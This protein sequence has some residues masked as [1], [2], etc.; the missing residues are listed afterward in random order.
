V[1][2]ERAKGLADV[3]GRQRE[4]SREIEAMHRHKEAQEGRVELNIGGYRFETSVQA[5]RRVPHTFFDAYFSG[6]YAQDVCADGSIFVDRDGKHFGHVLE[7]MR[8]GHVSVA[9]AGAC[10]S[11][12]LLRALKREFGFYCIELVVEQPA[13]PEQLETAYVMGGYEG[14]EFGN[15]ALSGMERFDASSGQWSAAASMSTPRRAFGACALGG[16]LYVLGGRDNDNRWLSS[17]EKYSPVSGT[18]S[19]VTPMPQARSAHVAVTVGSAIY[20]LGGFVVRG[21]TVASVLKFDSM[22]GTWS[23]VAPM[24]QA[25]CAVAACA[26]GS[27]IFV[28]GGFSTA[29]GGEVHASVY[30]LDTVA[31]EWSTLAPIPLGCAFHSASI[32]DGMIYIVGAG[33]TQKAVLR[34]DPASDVWSAL[35]S[36]LTTKREGCSFV[37][38]G[39]LYAAGGSSS[40]SSVER[41]DLVSNTWT[42]V[43]DMLQARLYPCAVT[44]GSTGPTEE[45]NLFDSLIAKASER[46]A[47]I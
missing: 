26:I 45:Q 46:C 38:G 14:P 28:L 30:K 3:D 8:D 36:T 37:L 2:D 23:Q 11:V 15:V 16:G 31:N 40:P 41:Y 35:T 44:I 25:L 22:R 1:A 39:C 7:Y 12:A 17:V 18:W 10:P 4:L 24:P 33:P 47:S 5:L 13:E 42:A 29:N 21:G 9:E 32:M 43:A 27:D 6:R 19:A 20:V 34:F